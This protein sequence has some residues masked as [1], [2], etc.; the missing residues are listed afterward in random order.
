MPYR[1]SECKTFFSQMILPAV[2]SGLLAVPCALG[3]LFLAAKGNSAA[4]LT[5]ILWFAGADVFFWLYFF[6]H[7]RF[8]RD[9][10]VIRYCTVFPSRIDY[11][12]VSGMR[13]LY[14]DVRRPGAPTCIE[15]SLKNG[16]EKR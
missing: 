12:E 11:A 13:C 8:E 3:L 15:F 9:F 1:D 6:W 14:N 7:V 4:V 5:L 16:K 10:A 2:I